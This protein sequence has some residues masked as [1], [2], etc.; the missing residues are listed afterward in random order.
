MAAVKEFECFFSGFINAR[1]D[2]LVQGASAAERIIVPVPFY[3]IKHR[4]EVVLFDSGQTP[5]ACVQG[6]DEPFITMMS[7]EEKAVNI[8]KHF[9]ITPESVKYIILSHLHSDHAAGIQDFPSARIIIQQQE[10]ECCHDPDFPAERCIQVNGSCDLYNDGS[11]QLIFTP[12]H[13]PGHQSLLINTGK[14][15]FLLTADAAYTQ[16]ALDG[17][18]PH[19]AVFSK[20]AAEGVKIIPGH[21]PDINQYRGI[22]CM[23]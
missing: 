8:L 18:N 11:V 12:G 14:G 21:E 1:K 7:E 16:A 4:D 5:S 9:S 3:L 15:R 20:Y 10:L 22:L 2:L 19:S 23:Q 13:T 6:A 17:M